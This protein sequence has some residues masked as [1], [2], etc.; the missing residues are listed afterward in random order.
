MADIFELSQETLSADMMAQPALLA[1]ARQ[2]VALGDYA[3]NKHKDDTSKVERV[4]KAL[5]AKGY[6]DNRSDPRGKPTEKE[7]ESRIL[8]SPEYTEI[9]NRLSHLNTDLVELERERD[10]AKA[11]FYGIEERGTMLKSLASLEYAEIRQQDR[12]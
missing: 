2:A 9:E 1:R 7:I 12:R 6:L 5:Y 11:V 10:N 3:V 8:I 4:K